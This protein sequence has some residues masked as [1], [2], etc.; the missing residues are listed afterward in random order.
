MLMYKNVLGVWIFDE[1]MKLVDKLLFKPE[2]AK[3]KLETDV[4]K[5]LVE[6]HKAKTKLNKEELQKIL[7]YF[8]ENNL[9]DFYLPNLYITKRGVKE[10]VTEDNFIIQTINHIE[11]LNKVINMLSKRLREWYELYNPEFSNSVENH[12]ALAKTITTENPKKE[13]MSMGAD[14]KE[15]DLEPIKRI[16]L[17]II[18]VDELREE[19]IGYLENVMKG[20]CPNVQ[21]VAGT[22][23]G[24]KL[25]SI[26]GSLEK[27]TNFP[28]STVQL[29][30][31]EKALFRHMKTGARPPKFGVI[32]N[33]HLV[34]A[35]K[36]KEKGKVARVL[37]NKILLAA[38]VDR[39]KGEFIG[40]ELL[41]SV[42]K[43]GK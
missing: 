37:A 21:T 43:R 8:E 19:Q 10:S 33:H 17:K 24:G 3:E 23:I 1:N 16:A 28:A 2:E 35:V 26:A 22:L 18:S 20:Y 7:T 41:K 34:N 39:F 31:A 42:E 5:E 36:G 25:V 14:L 30:G 15:E 38:K 12:V 6:K 13:K 29:L 40:D 32:M 9:K 11:E 4:E 27:L